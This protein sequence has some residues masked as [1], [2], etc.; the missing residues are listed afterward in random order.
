MFAKEWTEKLTKIPIV[1]A[2]LRCNFVFGWLVIVPV[3]FPV[4]DSMNN[5]FFKLS[6]NAA[7]Q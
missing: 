2:A 1:I 3:A 6:T 4:P 7:W 5:M